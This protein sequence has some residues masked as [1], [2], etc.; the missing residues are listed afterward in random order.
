MHIDLVH[1]M[2]LAVASRTGL[3]WIGKNVDHD[4]SAAGE[5]EYSHEFDVVWFGAERITAVFT[6]CYTSE[7]GFARLIAHRLSSV[8]PLGA[9]I[10]DT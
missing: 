9:M 10:Q 5:A 3:R 4:R 8:W 2:N 6:H 1:L 7:W